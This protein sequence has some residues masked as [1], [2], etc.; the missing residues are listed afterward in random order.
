[1]CYLGNKEDQLDVGELPQGLTAWTITWSLKVPGWQHAWVAQSVGRLPS[2]WGV[3]PEYWDWA[4]AG[5]PA[6]REV[7]SSPFT[8]PPAHAF[9]NN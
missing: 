4:L 3:T 2:A 9:T 6:P 8:P 5:L 7:C 1:M